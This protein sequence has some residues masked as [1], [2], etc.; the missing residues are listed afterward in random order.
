MVNLLALSP[1]LVLLLGA[2]PVSPALLPQRAWRPIRISIV[3]ATFLLLLIN[4]RQPGVVP[5]LFPGFASAPDLDLAFD[6]GA[7]ALFFASIALVALLALELFAQPDR[8][9]SRYAGRF[10]TLAGLLAFFLAANWTTLAASW[11][12]TDV[13]LMVWSI[14]ESGDPESI[15]GVWRNLALSQFGA[16]VFLG[17]GALTLNS[18]SSLRFANAS[19]EGLA[20]DLV[21]LAAWIR[22][23]LFP[24]L[25]AHLDSKPGASSDAM[26][27]TALVLLAGTYLL[28]RA[29]TM[30]KGE[31]AYS[32]L[33]YSTA[34][35]ATGATAILTLARREE[36]VDIHSVAIALAAPMLLTAFLGPPEGSA[37]LTIWL[38]LGAFNFVMLAAGLF[39]IRSNTRNRPL[40]RILWGVGVFLAAGFPL[41]PS[42]LG[43]TGLYTSAIRVGEAPLVAALVAATTLVLLPLWRGFLAE[44]FDDVHPPSPADYAGLGAILLPIAVEGLLPFSFSSLFGR[45]VEDAGAFA[46]DAV[47][48][49][50]T[51]LMPAILLFS[52]IFPIAASL[53][54][55][56]GWGKAGIKLGLPPVLA[57]A[58]DLTALG[59]GIVAMLDLIAVSARQTSALIEQHP[60]GWI[61]FA[62]IW[63][64]VW[65]LNGLGT[66]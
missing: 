34:L 54:L 1:L 3:L 12:L 37:A 13:G 47:F 31:F 59:R 24:F 11:L 64:A 16:L 44:P 56:R 62:A 49:P 40:R 55:A 53:Y 51:L 22:S 5:Y 50:Q 9:Y 63:V 58:L 45:N 21:L 38:G 41:T 7:P 43:R 35:F 20:A 6:F 18:G 42:F 65:L 61:L 19:L 66:R 60:L 39:L 26:A 33:L 48:R 29:L 46:F 28:V 57:Q 25:T 23:G 2:L 30:M 17:A 8:P 52:L 4:S 36:G 10:A 32:S 27:R 14:N 15:G